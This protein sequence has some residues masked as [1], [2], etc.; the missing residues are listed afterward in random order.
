MMSPKWAAEI[1]G[2]QAAGGNRTPR[3]RVVDKYAHEMN[4]GRWRPHAAAIHITAEGRLL[5]G[6]HRLMAVVK[7]GFPVAMAILFNADPEDMPVMDD[8]TPRRPSDLLA[9]LGHKNARHLEAVCRLIRRYDSVPVTG[10]LQQFISCVLSNEEVNCIVERHPGIPDSMAFI[11]FHQA[12]YRPLNLT[13]ATFVHYMAAKTDREKADEFMHRIKD[14]VGLEATSPTYVLRERLQDN[15]SSRARLSRDHVLA[16]MVKA[17][18]CYEA[19]GTMKQ[20]R[21][22]S[23]ETFPRFRCQWPEE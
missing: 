22:S 16:L 2:A 1:L 20:L 9:A 14:G 8:M 5:N 21:W 13:L 6:Q 17:W 7:C 18:L 10:R 4:S 15:Q 23:N 12:S 3:R 19:G 11:G